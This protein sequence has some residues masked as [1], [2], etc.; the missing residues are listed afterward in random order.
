MFVCDWIVP[1][2]LTTNKPRWISVIQQIKTN[3]VTPMPKNLGRCSFAFNNYIF[4]LSASCS[5][6]E[7]LH[8]MRIAASL[9]NN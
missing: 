7:D 8:F 5:G 1:K 3:K 2:I 6:G 9:L 4:K